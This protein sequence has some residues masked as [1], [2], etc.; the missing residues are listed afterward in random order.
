MITQKVV[1][2]VSC[3]VLSALHIISNSQKCYHTLKADNSLS[4]TPEF[5]HVSEFLVFQT[6][7]SN[8]GH[9]T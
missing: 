2:N 9:L 3:P 7:E 8:L 1:L 5:G 6:L 4:E